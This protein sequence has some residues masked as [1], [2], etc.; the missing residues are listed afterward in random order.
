M[1][2]LK[3]IAILGPTGS[4]KSDLALRLAA[5]FEGEVVNCDSLQIY[6]YFDIGTA[7]LPLDRRRGIPHHL[8]DIIDPDQDF[9]LAQYVEAAHRAVGEIVSR[10]LVPLFVGGT[11]LYLKSLLRGIFNGPP[12][13]WPLRQRLRAIVESE[14]A[15]ALH[16]ELARVD[17]KTANRLHPQDE[18][19]MIR[20]LEVWENT[21]RSITDLQLQFDKARPAAECRV[22]V[23]DRPRAELI[24]RINSR[25][26]QMFAEG[27]VEETRS[28]LDRGLS[29]SR[30][31]SQAVGY[32]E[33]VE[34]LSGVRNLQDTIVLVKTRT[35]QFAKRQMTWFR[36]QLPL[37]WIKVEPAE[38]AVDIAERLTRE[39]SAAAAARE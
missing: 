9:S 37:A 1:S 30:T 23:L 20:A 22:Y 15:E 27:L 29:L 39:I 36:R 38:A 13:N 8:I 35:R 5:D 26:D 6:R 4:G 32:R 18:R 19:R 21:G 10:G 12:A 7:K 2:N 28:L 34:H 11:P 17:P 25:V 24:E 33:V 3:V 31:A 14:G 16:T